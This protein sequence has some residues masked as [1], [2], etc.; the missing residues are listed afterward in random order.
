MRRWYVVVAFVVIVV[1]VAAYF[2]FVPDAMNVFRSVERITNEEQVNEMALAFVTSPYTDDY[3]VLRVPGWFDNLSKSEMRAARLEIQLLD[4]DGAKK[5]KI[6][7]DVQDIPANT[8]KTFDI[9]AGTISGDR[10]ATIKVVWVEVY[11]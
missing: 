6:T 10:T 5:E 9:N 3:D 4:E 11:Q 2:L 8:R 1:A 7:Y